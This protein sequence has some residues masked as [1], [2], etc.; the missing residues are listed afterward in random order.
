MNRIPLITLAL[1][2]A[3]C[4]SSNTPTR[5]QYDDTA[6]AI[7]STT[8]TS[9]GGGDISSMTDSVTIAQ[10]AMPTGFTAMGDGHFQ[11]SRLGLDYSYSIACKDAAGVVGPC[12]LTTDQATVEVAWSGNLNTTNLDASVMRNGMWSI[13]GLTSDTATFSGSGTFSF[14]ATLRS[15]FRPGATATYSFDAS[16]SYDAIQIA[17]RERQVIGGTATF[18]VSAHATVTGAGTSNSD[19]SFDVH[20]AITFHADHTADL[21]LRRFAKSSTHR[22][23]SRRSRLCVH[24]C[25]HAE[26]HVPPRECG[27]TGGGSR[28][29]RLARLGREVHP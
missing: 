10:G 22:R 6:Q 9:G 11:G 12:G 18:D 1:S 28:G 27:P 14:D 26:L 4:T 23:I 7:A 5:E 29:P 21:R 19:K 20:A 8:A 16:A 17:T 24:R 13:T 3:A 25:G 2:L 15:I